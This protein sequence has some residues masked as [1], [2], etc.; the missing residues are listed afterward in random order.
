MCGIAVLLPTSGVAHRTAIWKSEHCLHTIGIH[1]CHT[2][3][4]LQYV[5]LSRAKSSLISEMIRSLQ[6]SRRLLVDRE[7]TA[8]MRGVMLRQFDADAAVPSAGDGSRDIAAAYAVL[9]L[10]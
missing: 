1:G 10:C 5:T 8:A 4:F 3:P 6:P 9:L 2:Q 7:A